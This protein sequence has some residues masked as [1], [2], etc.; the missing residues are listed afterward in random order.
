M[1][2][3]RGEVEGECGWEDDGSL[4]SSGAE[5]SSVGIK[6]YRFRMSE[7]EGFRYRVMV[8]CAMCSVCVCLCVCVCVCARVHMHV[9]VCVYVC[10]C[11][12]VR[13]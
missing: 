6:P 2:G 9:F 4:C 11:A 5:S 7:I 3:K 13:E 12:C 10:V 1:R 8:K